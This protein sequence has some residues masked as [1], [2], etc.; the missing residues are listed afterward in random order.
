MVPDDQVTTAQVTE[1]WEPSGGRAPAGPSPDP[2]PAF[3]R[4]G[5][6]VVLRLVGA[7]GMGVVHQ[8]YDPELD[9]KVAIKLLHASPCQMGGSSPEAARLQREAQAIAQL[10]HP[11]VIT[12]YDVGTHAGRVFIAMEFVEGEDLRQWLRTR[13]RSWRETLSVFLQAGEGLAAAHAAGLVHRD[14]KPANVL[15]GGDGRA[16]VLDFGLARP[17]GQ[18]PASAVEPQAAVGPPTASA[19]DSPL[20]LPGAIV[21]TPAYMAP[22]QLCG[23]D[24]DP[25]ADQYAFAVALHEGLYSQRPFP[26]S[27]GVPGPSA[28]SRGA[29]LP[30]PSH[31]PVPARVGRV[32]QRALSA[33]PADRFPSMV[34]LLQALRRAAASRLRAWGWAAAG[35]GVLALA[36]ALVVRERSVP[37]P[38]AGGPERWST[39][40]SAGRAAAVKQA[41][42]ATGSPIAAAAFER[43]SD[44]LERYGQAWVQARTEAC[45]ATHARHEQSSELLDLRMVCLDRRLRETAALVSL[46]EK[47][48][49]G[50]VVEAPKAALALRP[51]EGCA[52]AEA[53]TAPVPLPPDPENRARAA[54]LADRLARAQAEAETGRLGQALAEGRAALAAAEALGHDPLV[55]EAHLLVGDVLDR[56]G[57]YAEASEELRLALVAAQRGRHEEAV[58]RALA[59]LV[60]V[61]GYSRQQPESFELLA[62]LGAATLDRLGGRELLRAELAQSLGSALQVNRRLVEAVEQFRIAGE[63]RALR[64]GPS[65]YLTAAARNN[66]ATVHYLQGRY[67]EAL[68]VHRE[69]LTALEA[70]LGPQHP[71]VA[72]N[73]DNIG[74]SLSALGHP[75]E[76]RAAHAR[77]H[78]IRQ[79]VFGDENVQTASSLA[80]LAFIDLEAGRLGDA[81]AAFARVLA[82]F[83]ATLGKSH[84]YLAYP[85]VGLGRCHLE[86][87]DPLRAVELLEP[88]V[89]RMSGQGVFAPVDLAEARFGLARTLGALGRDPG[90]ARRLA[91]EALAALGQSAQDVALR[92]KIERWLAAR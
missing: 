10:S 50:L 43:V 9:R 5:R 11:N 37:A 6:F 58:A 48:D 82:V 84:P 83:T 91:D 89:Q 29:V 86:Q 36:T 35:L 41:F 32:L 85:E 56:S 75:D 12:V 49:A 4:I 88:A 28:G 3:S 17:V 8:A 67:A 52:D 2:A 38:C 21:G 78:A 53:L 27:T 61:D 79:A 20:T 25:R 44:A 87:G 39:V 33:D 70:A 47:A 7:G 45:L 68:S 62:E 30:P 81:S 51:L 69:V 18:R 24:V 13:Q 59:L 65:H 34:E 1:G 54:A 22:E 76:A 77:A 92:A 63:L 26:D 64:L 66:T 72:V 46:L 74:A 80:N 60:W 90:R 16:R 55:A 73:L 23:H 14:F 15:V 57:E 42:A 31:H 71:T 40:W 19:L